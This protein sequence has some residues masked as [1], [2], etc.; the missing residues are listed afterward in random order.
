MKSQTALVARNCRLNE[1]IR[2]VHDLRIDCLDVTVQRHI[3][4]GA[5][6]ILFSVYRPTRLCRIGTYRRF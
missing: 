2:M 6:C 1:W 5:N 4:V 3:V